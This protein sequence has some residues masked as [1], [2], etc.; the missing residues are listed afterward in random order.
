MD[1]HNYI[2][3][4]SEQVRCKKALPIV[5]KELEAHIDDQKKAFMSEGMTEREAEEA[6]VR[7]MGDPVSVGVDMDR[8][9]R[10]KMNW[11]IILMITIVSLAGLGLQWYMTV[12]IT[13]V[14]LPFLYNPV[15]YLFYTIAGVVVM[16]A[17]CYVDYTRIAYRA[18]ELLI[19]YYIFLIV[20]VLSGPTVNGANY[21]GIWFLGIHF[22]VRM[23]VFLF[24]P[25]YCAVVYSYEGQGYQGLLKA[26]LIT[27]PQML[28]CG[29]MEAFLMIPILAIILSVA[30]YKKY[31]KV[32][33]KKMV[34]AIW[35]VTVLLPIICVMGIMRSGA[36]YQAMRLK[37][38][39]NPEKYAMEEGY[40]FWV[41]RKLLQGSKLIGRNP[42]VLEVSGQ[43]PDNPSLILAYITSYYGVLA[44]GLVIGMI[45][46]V[47]LRLAKL[48]VRQKNRL[49]SLI[50]IGCTAAVVIHIIMYVLVNM[51]VIISGYVYCP[52]ITY[53]GTGIIFMDI[54]FGI[55]LS[56]YR[57]QNVSE[58]EV[59]K[60]MFQRRKCQG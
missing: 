29:I 11:R 10:P 17:V 46:F 42:N 19:I 28:I 56:I 5:V 57:Y 45:L 33:V 41:I 8:I 15:R 20:S 14:A 32:A 30:V 39:M 22:D 55:M 6:A 23:S 27:I 37:V 40:Q 48:S 31:F 43:V 47:I 25:L 13:D 58:A 52:F 44:A 49:G 16:V 21:A 3:I 12:S 4:L 36:P 9:H 35:G 26:V 60:K 38:M 24:I 54:T 50:G 1:R 53:G 18:K 51:G 2:D 59:P 34:A 7:E